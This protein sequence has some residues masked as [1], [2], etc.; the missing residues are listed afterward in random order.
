MAY[1]CW[2][3]IKPKQPN[4]TYQFVRAIYDT[5]SFLSEVSSSPSS[6]SGRA[7]STDTCD[8]FSPPFSIVHRFRQVFRAIS[9]IGTELLWVSSNWASC[10][11]SSMLRSPQ[12][13]VTYDLVPTSPAVFHLSCSSNLDRFRDRWQVTVQVLLC[14][15]LLPELVQ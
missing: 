3:A 8:H 5:T 7:I 11:C 13:R 10:L 6:S 14:G 4:L 1:K 12:E 15:V 2:Y 9:C